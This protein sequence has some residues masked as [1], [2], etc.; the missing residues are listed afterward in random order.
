MS[1]SHDHH[2]EDESGEPH[3]PPH[4][5]RPGHSHS[6][7]HAHA[8]ATFGYRFGVGIALNL[9]IVALELIYG[10]IAHSVA[11]IADA[12]HNLSD[13]LGLFV[14]YAATIASAR[15]P[16]PRFTYGL[17]ATS[18]MAA[19]FNA[20]FLL[21]VTGALGYAAIER[22]FRPEPVIAGAMMAVAAIGM[23]IN[24][25]TAAL[26]AYGRK[27]DLNIRGAFLHMAA[28][29]AISAG[30]V[31]AGFA[32]MLTGRLWIDPLVSL[33]ISALIIA[34]T[35]GL[36]RESLAMAL[37]GVPAGITTAEVRDYLADLPEVSAL[38]DLHIWPMSTSET[39]LTAHLL[40]PDGHPGDAFLAQTANEL[41]RRFGIG[42]VTLQIE[43]DRETV[44]ALE[45][46][47]VV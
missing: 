27:G 29:A 26:F 43:V 1:H 37:A 9:L 7:S 21:V 8:P 36:L 12:G 25:I 30:V 35:W 47:H 44:C 19:L 33:G 4:H 42:H 41:R 45:P 13:V 32:I 22:L 23:V 40:T 6:H 39:A 20:V 17:R 24:L 31:L 5:H 15:A 14:A 38:H 34:G 18:I 16:S 10:I 11:L 3:G 28:D 46:D 2:I